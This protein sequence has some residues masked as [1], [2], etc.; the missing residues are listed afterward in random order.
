MLSKAM[1]DGC[2][3][4]PDAMTWYFMEV[5]LIFGRPHRLKIPDFAHR[6]M[7]NTDGDDG[8]VS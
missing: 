8:D 4:T 5:A 1:F 7:P 2:F 3:L 6:I